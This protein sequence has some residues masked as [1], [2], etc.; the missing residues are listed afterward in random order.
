MR[1]AL[2]YIWI[3]ACFLFLHWVAETTAVAWTDCIIHFLLMGYLIKDD[4]LELWHE[5]MCEEAEEV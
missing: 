2:K 5:V 1:Q 3:F 4:V